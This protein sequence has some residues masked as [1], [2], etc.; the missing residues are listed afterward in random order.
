MATNGVAEASQLLKPETIIAK[1]ILESSRISLYKDV[2]PLDWEDW[3]WQLKNRIRNKEDLSKVVN[4]TS[5]EEKGLSQARGRM[6][7]SITPYW[8]TLI[9]VDDENCPIRRQS[10]P[11]ANE[12]VV[13]P[14]EMVDPCA[15]DRDSPVPGLVHRYPDRVLVL[16]TDQ[17]AMYCRHCTRRRLVG[18]TKETAGIL[19]RIDAIVDYLKAN[20]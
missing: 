5:E 16:A 7:M 17:C 2:D 18:E 12:F 14:H 11:T 9:D 1:K 4:L 19:E 13:S 10:I 3:H 6:A 15:E 20:R 8:A